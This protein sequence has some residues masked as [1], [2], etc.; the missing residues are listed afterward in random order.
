MRYDR[1]KLVE[2]AKPYF[3]NP[4]VKKMYATSDGNMF[5]E[6]GSNF[7]KAHSKHHDLK[8]F[9][10]TRED[11]VVKPEEPII[12]EGTEKT[13]REIAKELG[14]NVPGRASKETIQK[15]IDEHLEK[16]KKE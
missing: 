6:S 7:A 2:K 1:D 9:D 5:Y 10:I 11:Y 4:D 3:K 13:P 16:N 15:M 14:L 8:L 12:N